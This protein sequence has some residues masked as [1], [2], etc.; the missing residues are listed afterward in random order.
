MVDL[1]CWVTG[2]KPVE[3]TAGGNRICT[4]GTAFRYRDH[5]AATFRFDSGLIGRI[6]ANFGCVHPHQHVVRVFGT[7]ATFLYDDRGPRIQFSRDPSAPAKSIELSP[8]PATKGDLIP[9]F[10]QV[11]LNGEDTR[12]QTQHEFNILSACFAVD[13]SLASR[14]TLEVQYL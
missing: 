5:L 7:K 1:M 6:T 3:V 2:Q 11:V 4:T 9:S 13:L 12:V 14:K 8:L 10:V